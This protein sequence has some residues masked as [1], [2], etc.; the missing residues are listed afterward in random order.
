MRRLRDVCNDVVWSH[1][2]KVRDS[3]YLDRIMTPTVSHLAEQRLDLIDKSCF[4]FGNGVPILELDERGKGVA[5][6][7]RV[8]IL[9]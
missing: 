1:R 8:V 9:S 3:T 7:Q 5:L 4:V 6:I 2:T